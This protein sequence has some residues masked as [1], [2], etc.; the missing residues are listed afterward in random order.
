MHV[1][2][3]GRPTP[4]S[5]L[6]SSVNKPFPVRWDWRAASEYVDVE[7][8]EDRFRVNELVV[9]NAGHLLVNWHWYEVGGSHETSGFRVKV[10]QLIA[11]VT[12]QSAGGQHVIMSVRDPADEEAGRRELQSAA[13]ALFQDDDR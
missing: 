10:R 7:F 11:L 12:G 9:N 6:V 5:E 1:A 2:S 13:A 3:Y 8:G 4:G